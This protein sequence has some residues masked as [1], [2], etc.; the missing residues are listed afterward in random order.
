MAGVDCA[1]S[2]VTY[3]AHHYCGYVVP[4]SSLWDAVYIVLQNAEMSTFKRSIL[5]VEPLSLDLPKT[6]VVL[7]PP[8]AHKEF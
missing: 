5:G 7:S 2:S 6:S 1:E 4:A 8:R 3:D